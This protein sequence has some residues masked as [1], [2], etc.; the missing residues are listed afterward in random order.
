MIGGKGKQKSKVSFVIGSKYS[1]K[2]VPKP[3]DKNVRLKE[4]PSHILA[5]RKFSGPPP[6]DDRVKK[7]RQILEQSLED[8]NLQAKNDEETLVYGYHDPFLTPNILR[9]NEVAVVIEGKV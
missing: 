5:V 2:T 7:E 8:V 1:L 9:K 6:K 4:V 3:M